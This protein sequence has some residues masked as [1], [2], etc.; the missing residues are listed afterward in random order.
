M[1]LTKKITPND[2]RVRMDTCIRV[3]ET[4]EVFEGDEILSSTSRVRTITPLDNFNKETVLVKDVCKGV[5]TATR[6]KAYAKAH[7]PE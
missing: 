6:K 3:T 7:P 4:V 2:I 1:S 5:F